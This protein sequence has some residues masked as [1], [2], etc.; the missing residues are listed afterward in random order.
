[1]NLIPAPLPKYQLFASPCAEQV[2]VNKRYSMK[3]YKGFI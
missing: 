1:M 2:I 3:Q